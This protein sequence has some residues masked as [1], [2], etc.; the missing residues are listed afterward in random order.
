MNGKEEQVVFQV[1]EHFMSKGMLFTAYDVTKAVKKLGYPVYHSEVKARLRKLD[2]GNYTKTLKDISKIVF[3]GSANPIKA[4]VYHP[5]TTSPENYNP[6]DLSDSDSDA[7][8]DDSIQT[9]VDVIPSNNAS[10]DNVYDVQLDRRGRFFIR[11]KVVTAAGFNAGDTLCIR[12]VDSIIELSDKLGIS[13]SLITIDR[14][15][16]F[17]VFEGYFMK[18]FGKV[19][20]KIMVVASN[21]KIVITEYNQ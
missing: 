16:N 18:A 8:T 5:R 13:D 4:L 10:P 15:K 21:K 12:A 7:N 3:P 20:H 9:V 6:V 11:A 19:P 1:V 14:Y 17:L 2:L